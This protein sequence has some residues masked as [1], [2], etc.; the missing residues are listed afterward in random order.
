M[1][2]GA[3]PFF[4][5]YEAKDGKYIT[6]ACAEPHLWANLCRALGREDYIPHQHDTSQKREEIFA[7]LREAFRTRTRD[8]WFAEFKEKDICVAPVYDLNEVFT[9]P[10]IIQRKML[11]ELDEPEVGAV[12]QVGIPIK[13]SGTPGQVRS[14]A[15]VLGENTEEILLQL[16]YNKEQME[17]LEKAGAIMRR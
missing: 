4:S 17:E 12:R 7:F 13:L 16:G 11:L 3:F 8:E 14:L 15:P 10:Q 5:V 6:I 2:N 1:L 9:D